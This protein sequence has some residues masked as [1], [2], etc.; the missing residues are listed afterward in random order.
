M[1]ADISIDMDGDIADDAAY[2]DAK[3]CMEASLN[4]YVTNDMGDVG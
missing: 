3:I 4:G 2:C 1:Y